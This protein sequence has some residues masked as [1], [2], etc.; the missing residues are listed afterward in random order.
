[1]AGEKQLSDGRSDG[2]KLGQATSDKVAFFNTTPIS[3]RASS[4]QH[5]SVMATASST[6][7]TS[8]MK[9]CII[10]IMSTLTNLGL[11]KGSA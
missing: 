11:W 9:A 7:V 10:E 2:A 1:M 8:D 4:W 3:Q 6:D 5:T